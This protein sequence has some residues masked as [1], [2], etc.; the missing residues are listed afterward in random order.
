MKSDH[1]HD[2]QTND[3]SKL[4]QKAWAATEE[5]GLKIALVVCVLAV[6]VAAVRI[7]NHSAASTQAGA[8]REFGVSNSADEFIRLADKK[9]WQGTSAAKWSR[10][11]GAEAKLT[12]AIQLM[13]SDRA[14]AVSDLEDARGQFQKL[15][16]SSDPTIKERAIFGLARAEETLGNTEAAAVE[17]AKL[18]GDS[19][20]NSVYHE[21]A[22]KRTEYLTKA[23]P[24][25]FY[26][27][28]KKQNPKPPEA[29][30]PDDK[31]TTPDSGLELPSDLP[32]GAGSPF[33]AP[34]DQE[35]EKPA[36]EKPESTEEA[37]KKLPKLEVEPPSE[38]EKEGEEKEDAQDSKSPAE[39][40]D[41]EAESADE[42]ESQD[43][44]GAD[45]SADGTPTDEAAEKSGE[46]P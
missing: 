43:A 15:L 30:K 42:K 9:E 27:W 39:N 19:Y 37:D 34:A 44:G 5:H 36:A 46:S 6:V 10:L 38:A 23:D 18:A 29:P 41:A 17:Y 1:R 45:D 13:F 21:E 31:G 33:D 32:F 20:A 24:Q 28:F 11:V 12:Q 4:T 16:D 22:K 8:W 7:Y 3:L 14:N 25:V 40:S 26:A 2:L 35:S